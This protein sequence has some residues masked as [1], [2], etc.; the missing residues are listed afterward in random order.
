MDTFNA[1]QG[2]KLQYIAGLFDGE[3]FAGIYKPC[4]LQ[5]GI[6][7][8]S[9]EVL[10]LIVNCF[11]GRI[12]TI[13]PKK[14]NRATMYRLCYTANAA[15]GF[16]K[17]I[18]PYLIVKRDV[19]Q[20]VLETWERLKWTP[21]WGIPG[22]IK[23]YRA[24]RLEISPYGAQLPGRPYGAKDRKKRDNRGYI[25]RYLGGGVNK[26]TVGQQEDIFEYG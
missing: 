25:L 9:V 10:S 3:G 13:S 23:E 21:H 17:S 11:G 15:E 7:I 5:T 16:L 1:G 12:S 26:K 4:Q 19:T 20:L 2:N 8:G 6:E 18:Y 22:V 24:R 14:N